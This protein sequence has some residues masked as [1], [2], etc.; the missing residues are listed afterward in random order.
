MARIMFDWDVRAATPLPTTPIKKIDG[1]TIEPWTARMVN[2]S[3]LWAATDDKQALAQA[4]KWLLGLCQCRAAPDNS[5]TYGEYALALATAYD[6]LHDELP[7]EEREVVRK[8]LGEVCQGLYES[9]IGRARGW[10]RQIYLHHDYWIPT[11][12]LGVGALALKG[13]DERWRTWYGL[14]KEELTLALSLLG[15]DGAWHEGVGPWCYALASMLPFVEAARNV[16]GDDFY[17]FAWFKNTALWRLHC[18]LPD[19][20]YVF[21]GDS[22][23]NGRY[24]Q[25][26]SASSHLLRLLAA[27]FRDGHAQWLADEDE[28]FDFAGFEKARA[29]YKPGTPPPAT[30]SLRALY[31]AGWS[32][33]WYDPTV[34]PIPPDGLPTHKVFDNL[35]YVVARSGWETDAALLT[36]RAGPVAGK[37][38][39]RAARRLGRTFAQRMTDSAEHAHMDQNVITYY[40]R[41]T[42]WVNSP[43]YGARSSARHTTLAINGREQVKSSLT[44]PLLLRREFNEDYVYLLG[45]ASTAYPDGVWLERFYRHLV[46]LKPDVLVICDDVRTREPATFEWRMH[47]DA[48]LP[49]PEL[50]KGGWHLKASDDASAS[51][52]V[53]E[54]LSPQ[55]LTFIRPSEKLD[56][57]VARTDVP[58]AHTLFLVVLGQRKALAEVAPLDVKGGAGVL[59]KSGSSRL[60]VIFSLEPLC[61][62]REMQLD[63]VVPAPGADRHLIVGLPAVTYVTVERARGKD[64][65]LKVSIKPGKDIQTSLEGTLLLD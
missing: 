53:T 25:M 14:A 31:S 12:G 21:Y 64:A 60:A 16:A 2:A 58:S 27:R 23:R 65:V 55:E 1:W 28:A 13:E 38:G 42:Y 41:G 29:T 40:A 45:D 62:A 39:C 6:V 20:S 59:L 54:F 48:K 63:Y 49:F 9:A 8:H 57:L 24:G 11:C 33:I 4:Q 30:A 52:F 56:C 34:K 37:R 19:G 26:G 44:E 3:F 43:G 47:P 46:W 10:W 22:Y 15:D 51:T 35:G 18:R 5:Y 36:F 61:R 32:L 7:P 17:R 50:D